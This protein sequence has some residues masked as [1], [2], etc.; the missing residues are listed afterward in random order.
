MVSALYYRT[1]KPKWF[2]W[3]YWSYYI[4]VN[5]HTHYNMFLETLESIAPNFLLLF[6]YIYTGFIIV[7]KID[8][9]RVYRLSDYK[10]IKYSSLHSF[11]R[12]KWENHFCSCKVHFINHHDQSWKFN[13]IRYIGVCKQEMSNIVQFHYFFQYWY[14]TIILIGYWIQFYS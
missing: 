11:I 7:K 5:D 9:W 4:C 3:S 13:L 10:L 6:I 14:H 2:G 8:K 12:L 1:A